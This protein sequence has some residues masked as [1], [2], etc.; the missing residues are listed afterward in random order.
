VSGG[1]G[2]ANARSFWGNC[3]HVN[4]NGKL[5]QPMYSST[6]VETAPTTPIQEPGPL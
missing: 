4:D 3:F 6:G 5:I 2:L 1:L